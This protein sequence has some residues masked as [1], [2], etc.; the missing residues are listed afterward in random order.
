MTGRSPARG[1]ASLAVALACVVPAVPCIAQGAPDAQFREAFTRQY[2]QLRGVKAD[3]LVEELRLRVEL[4]ASR[5][6]AIGGASNDK[7]IRGF[8]SQL[9]QG[10]QGALCPGASTRAAT[11]PAPGVI[12][13]VTQA[14][15][16]QRLRTEENDVAE[17][18][19]IAQRVIDSQPPARLCA[20][21][22]LDDIR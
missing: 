2:D 20:A 5:G 16:S 4:V 3:M 10:L 14:A 8:E 19:A 21:A 7:R 18:A 1:P 17:L 22:S 15:K 12:D 11:R 9:L 6:S 13:S